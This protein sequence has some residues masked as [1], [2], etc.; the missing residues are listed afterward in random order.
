MDPSAHADHESHPQQHPEQHD[1]KPDRCTWAL[2]RGITIVVWTVLALVFAYFMAVQI[3]VYQSA[4]RCMPR[5]AARQ[6]S[7]ANAHGRA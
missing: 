4:G 6:P 7:A 2:Q 3:G 1:D 5:R